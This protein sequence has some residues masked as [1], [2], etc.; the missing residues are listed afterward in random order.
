M[1]CL[2]RTGLVEIKQYAI[3]QTFLLN[4]KILNQ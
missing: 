2:Y 4:L 1:I 3:S